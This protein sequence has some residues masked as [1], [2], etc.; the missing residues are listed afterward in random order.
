MPDENDPLYFTYEG[1]RGG[2]YFCPVG[3]TPKLI[4]KIISSPELVEVKK[5][6]DAGSGRHRNKANPFCGAVQE[7]LK[8]SVTKKS[9]P[10]YWMGDKRDALRL[11][12]N[13]RELA[14]VATQL[15]NYYGGAWID[16][17]PVDEN[18]QSRKF[19]AFLPEFNIGGHWAVKEIVKNL[20]YLSDYLTE[21]AEAPRKKGRRE[22][23]T[24]SLFLFKLENLF[25]EN[26]GKPYYRA[27]ALIW[28]AAAGSKKTAATVKTTLVRYRKGKQNSAIKV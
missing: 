18:L 17:H 8:Y 23:D 25:R 7:L 26:L 13:A 10:L 22:E 5:I 1:V 21:I 24:E 4:N 6:L 16:G 27:I 15:N 2:G 12:K 9:N 19:P 3:L 14:K 20:Q 11:S 28:Q